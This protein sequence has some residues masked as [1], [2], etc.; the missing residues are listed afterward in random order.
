MNICVCSRGFRGFSK[1]SW[2]QEMPLIHII[3]AFIMK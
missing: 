2:T 1:L 3:E